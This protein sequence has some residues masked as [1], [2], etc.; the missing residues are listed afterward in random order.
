M[1]TA[2]ECI[3][4]YEKEIDDLVDQVFNHPNLTDRLAYKFVIRFKRLYNPKNDFVDICEG[5]ESYIRYLNSL[6]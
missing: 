5:I 2:K 6:T 3:E 4:F 1:R